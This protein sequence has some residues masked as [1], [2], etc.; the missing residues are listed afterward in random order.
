MGIET[1]ANPNLGGGV[2]TFSSSTA[3]QSFSNSVGS[4]RML[5]N[6]ADSLGVVPAVS[7]SQGLSVLQIAALPSP[8]KFTKSVLAAG[9]LGHLAKGTSSL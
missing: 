1:A 9:Y 7:L 8:P 4:L 3:T 6:G 5:A 2:R